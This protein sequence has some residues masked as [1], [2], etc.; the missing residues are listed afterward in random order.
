MLGL[1]VHACNPST[2]GGRN[3]RLGYMQDSVSKNR[4]RKKASFS[5]N[6][7]RSGDLAQVLERLPSKSEALSSNPSTSPK[8]PNNVPAIDSVK[9]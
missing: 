3:R 5:K 7:T 6:K 2:W 8:S 1:V 4:K 9:I